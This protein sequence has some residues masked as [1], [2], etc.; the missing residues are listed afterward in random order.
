M[1]ISSQPYNF[2]SSDVLF[3]NVG[4]SFWGGVDPITGIIIDQTH[5]LCGECVTDKIL[6]IPSGRGSCT[7]SQVMLELIL[8]GKGP[9]AIVLRDVDSILCTGAIVAE[10]FF[11]GE[12]EDEDEDKDDESSFSKPSMIIPIIC[13]VGG[14]AYSQLRKVYSTC[15][16]I[17]TS[18]SL[19]NS[20]SVTIESREEG[21]KTGDIA[22]H[23]QVADEGHE[24]FTIITRDLLNVPDTLNA[25]AGVSSRSLDD[26]MESA[27]AQLA[28][29]TVR[30][31]ASIS[32]ATNLIPIS[33]AHIDAVT[34]IGMG[35]LKFAQKLS[36][37]GGKVAVPTTL[38]SQST[39]R[40][41]WEQLGVDASLAKNANAVG[42]A[43]LELGC[44]TS[45]TCAP[46]LLPTKP[47]FGDN[48]MWGESNA[49][50]YSN[51][52][53]GARTEKY[54]DYFDIC[55]ALIG[56]V[57]NIGVHLD[58]NRLPTIAIDATEL[59]ED[60]I[61]PAIRSESDDE[62]EADSIP[63]LAG[64]IYDIDSFYPTMG[65]LCGNLSDGRVPIILGFDSLPVSNDNLK[66]FCAAFG[67]T[68]TAP[69]FHMANV[70]PEAMGD[71]V[72]EKYLSC[73]ESTRRVNVTIDDVRNSY[74]TL[75]SGK[76]GIEKVDVVALGNP[77]LSLTELKRL[78][79]LI[80][81][82]DRPKR[83]DVKVIATLG[84]HIHSK[85]DDLGYMKHLKKFGVSI[86]NDTCWCML[87][88]PPIIPS[89]PDARIL[90]NSGKYAHYGPAL[91]NRRMRFGSMFDCVEAAKSGKIGSR[92]KD[93]LPRWLRSFS[94]GTQRLLLHAV[95]RLK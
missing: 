83:E 77:H 88:D 30:R 60:H 20:S 41:R 52:V 64:S 78:V 49:V 91:T 69:L 75:D 11:G 89:D 56:L 74:E 3:S 29:R 50:V 82:D 24:D 4:I 5:P 92:G 15:A 85:S 17:N 61:L 94:T 9:R 67:T 80:G 23:I 40:R 71:D 22:L 44:E 48:I 95:K 33:S 66:A 53:I 28:L 63:A 18:R 1:K 31:V 6:C 65:W 57:P 79:D 10:E 45:F 27:A 93:H 81:T 46:Y 7:G 42:S 8:N 16:D 73:C 34:F 38:N 12:D 2:T 43:Y 39:D 26:C 37:L 72:I 87:L 32:N 13:A 76:D 55:A 47:K 19:F 51:S 84:R 68:G 59:I 62:A 21:N 86:I 58:E 35:G 54:A 14:E 36:Q 70:T 90:T 25:D